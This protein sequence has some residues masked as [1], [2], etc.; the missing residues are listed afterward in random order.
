MFKV[1]VKK[2]GIYF[3]Y[4]NN[5]TLRNVK[6]WVRED[7]NK[8]FLET[9]GHPIH[10]EQE[11][12]S[13]FQQTILRLE[14]QDKP[15]HLADFF[16][17]TYSW[18]KLR[19]AVNGD[20]YRIIFRTFRKFKEY[21]DTFWD[22]KLREESKIIRDVL[23]KNI[24]TNGN[25]LKKTIRRLNILYGTDQSVNDIFKTPIFLIPLPRKITSA[26][27]KFIPPLKSIII[28]CSSKR[29]SEPRML[30][31]IMHELVHLFFEK[32]RIK[33]LFDSAEKKM[34][35]MEIEKL[36][37]SFNIIPS[38]AFGLKEIIATSLTIKLYSKKDFKNS[39]S[40]FSQLLCFVSQKI[41]S[42]IDLYFEKGKVIDEKFVEKILFFWKEFL[43]EK[44]T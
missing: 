19:K 9:I 41:E 32:E 2:L 23:T 15:I 8:I 10:N 14:N 30:E 25:Y 37:G 43:T 29:A 1:K 26:G 28:E 11:I 35:P 13:Q 33:M 18:E 38:V 42:E 16:Y 21:F 39:T 44:N 17:A 22:K 36:T 6:H 40:L 27:G 34:T 7:Y 31:I 24:K 20:D 3:F 5:L 12:L 4:L